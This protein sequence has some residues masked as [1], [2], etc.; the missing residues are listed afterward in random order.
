MALWGVLKETGTFENVRRDLCH[1][2]TYFTGTWRGNGPVTNKKKS[3][4]LPFTYT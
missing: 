2:F 3:P 4:V 1:K